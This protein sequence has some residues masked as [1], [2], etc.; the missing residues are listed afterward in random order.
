MKRRPLIRYQRS[1]DNSRSIALDMW[2][3]MYEQES[4]L[5]D[6]RRSNGMTVLLVLDRLDDPVTP[7]LTQWTYQ[8]MVHELIGLHHHRLDLRSLTGR[9]SK[10]QG[11]VVLSPLQDPFYSQ[12]MYDNYG[13]L[14]LA[15]KGLVDDFQVASKSNTNISS[16]EEMQRFV[17]NYPEFRSKSGHVSKHVTVLSELNKTITQRCLMAASAQEQELAC[18]SN[19]TAHHMELTALLNDPKMHE[20]EKLRLVILFALRYEQE[21]G[22]ARLRDQLLNL[23]GGLG[24]SKS[25]LATVVGVLQA[26]GAETRTGDLFGTKTFSARASK[27]VSSLKG[28]D[29]VY[30]QH[31]PL[32]SQTLENLAKGKLKEADYPTLGT[33][34]Q[35]RERPLEVVVFLVGGTTYEEA[36]AVAQL[37]LQA[38]REGGMRV[39][40]GG[41]MVHNSKSFLDHIS[42]RM[43]AMED[44]RY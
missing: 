17:E 37:N 35:T 39:T 9:A 33:A 7:L 23:L 14:G 27:M 12:H 26:A 6:F 25:K 41:T 22:G 11:E 4:S 36:R 13:D 30:T 15:V 1:S 28:V 16:I 21:V 20:D 43:K 8:A 19:M 44:H 31:Q 29:N 5:F 18:S 24:C 10:D 40:L 42:E 2:R 3:L 34:M 38:A 32:L